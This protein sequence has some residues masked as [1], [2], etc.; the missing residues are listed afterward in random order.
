MTLE[1]NTSSGEEEE[2]AEE[3]EEEAQS[4]LTTAVT[5]N[6]GAIEQ[7]KRPMVLPCLGSVV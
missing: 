6:K 5:I 2:K 1:T 7:T 4:D 3:E